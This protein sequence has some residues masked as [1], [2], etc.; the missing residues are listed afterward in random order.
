MTAEPLRRRRAALPARAGDPRARG[1]PRS[2][3]YRDLDNNLASSTAARGPHRRCVAAGRSADRERARTAA[4]G[5]AG[6]VRRAA[7]QLMPAEQALDEALNAS[8]AA[9]SRRPRLP[10]TS[11]R[12]VSPPE[13]I[14]SP[15]WCAR[16]RIFLPKRTPSTRRSSRR[17]RRSGRSATRRPSSA[18]ARGLPPLPPSAPS[19]KRRCRRN[20]RL[21]RAV[22]SAAVDG[23]GDSVAAVGRRGDGAVLA[24]RRRATSLRSRARALT[25]NRFRSAPKHCGEGRG[26]PPRP[27]YRE[28]QRCLRQVRAVRSG[29]GPRLYATLLGPVEPLS[30][31]SAAC[32][33]RPRAR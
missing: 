19:C 9:P 26:F 28:R 16:I 14:A 7:Q 13:T 11:W 21:R 22:K 4:R 10:S 6:A 2:S 3:G 32:W 12:F 5:A 17:S 25:G 18:P 24:P 15:N 33:S 31:T 23:E 8:S 30:R 20:F 1:W 27:R 29:A